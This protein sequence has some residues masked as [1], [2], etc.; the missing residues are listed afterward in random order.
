MFLLNIPWSGHTG[1][2]AFHIVIFQ[3]L[4]VEN[5]LKM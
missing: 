3:E 2:T 1:R 5:L 4:G